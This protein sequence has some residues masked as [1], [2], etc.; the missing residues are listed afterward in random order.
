M[1][2]RGRFQGEEDRLRLPP[3]AFRSA[4]HGW[5][6]FLTLTSFPAPIRH[7]K[8]LKGTWDK[9]LSCS[10]Q[11]QSNF[12]LLKPLLHAQILIWNVSVSQKDGV[13]HISCR[14]AVR[15]SFSYIFT[16]SSK[17]NGAKLSDTCSVRANWLC[18]GWPFCLAEMR[19]EFQTGGN[20]FCVLPDST[21]Q[22]INFD[23]SLR[24]REI[25]S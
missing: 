25:I 6:S 13:G 1:S 12:Q 24:C 8:N 10:H 18:M 9:N 22:G 16:G 19:R 20:F 23:Y 3:W 5:K 11:L 14:I 21:W 4:K 15:V 7:F 2:A 17:I